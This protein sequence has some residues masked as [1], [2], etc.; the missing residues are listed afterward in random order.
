MWDQK[1]FH[2]SSTFQDRNSV[3][4]EGGAVESNG[5]GVLLVTRSAVFNENRNPGYSEEELIGVLKQDLFVTKI[6]PCE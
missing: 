6:L 2:G 1:V 3:V 5:K 4:L